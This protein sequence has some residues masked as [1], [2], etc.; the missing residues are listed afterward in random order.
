[1][2]APEVVAL[3]AW[4]QYRSARDL[5]QNVNRIRK[6]GLEEEPVD[7]FW[8]RESTEDEIEKEQS[9][10]KEDQSWSRRAV[11][12]LS[13]LGR[14]LGTICIVLVRVADYMRMCICFK[15]D[16]RA[17]EREQRQATNADLLTRLDSDRLPWNINTAYYALCGAA[18]IVSDF[19]VGVTL[20]HH[21]ISDLA[22]KNSKSLLPLQRAALQDPSKA[23]GLAKLI[24]STQAFWFCVQ[25]IARIS[26]DLAITLLELNTFAHCIS[27]VCIY[28]FWWHKPYDVQTHVYI[29]DLALYQGY[30][31]DEALNEMCAN[32]RFDIMERTPRG[33]MDRLSRDRYIPQRRRQR[34]K[35]KIHELENIPGTGFILT[36][37]YD[38]SDDRTQYASDASLAFWKQL[39]DIRVTCNHPRPPEGQM[40]CTSW[41]DYLHRTRNWEKE[42]TMSLQTIQGKFVPLIMISTFLLY[43]GIHLLAWQ[44]R[45]P[46]EAEATM[47]R[48]ASVATALSGLVVLAD[49]IHGCG[50]SE[51]FDTSSYFG[52]ML[53]LVLCSV[54][55]IARSFLFVESFRALPY[56]PASIYEVPRWT[57]YI[58]HI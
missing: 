2:I 43:G 5:M 34:H 13:C 15:S 20:T 56:S 58:P 7:Q 57:A 49:N 19:G 51:F 16:L 50:V 47:W 21:G 31:L 3:N 24:T 6:L 35:H 37:T 55:T 48:A 52:W 4:L 33:D 44:Y 42:L 39:W 27:A 28:L 53:G 12:Y 22:H 23:S 17:F 26:Q 32:T 46:T 25:C 1:M 38:T 54:A 9:R 40:T 8:D 36:A 30:L 41:P 29:N 14:W 10:E 11:G 18:V 45:F